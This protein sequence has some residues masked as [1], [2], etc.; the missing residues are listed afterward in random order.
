MLSINLDYSKIMMSVCIKRQMNKNWVLDQQF[1]H[2]CIKEL[3]LKWKTVSQDSSELISN[4]FWF[5]MLDSAMTR[6]FGNRQRGITAVGTYLSAG[7]PSAKSK[8]TQ[9]KMSYILGS[10]I[11]LRKSSGLRLY[12]Q[13]SNQQLQ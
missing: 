11:G 10:F 13:S 6:T 3:Y 8:L 5:K 1:V 2:L 4:P 12:Y 9:Q 7:L